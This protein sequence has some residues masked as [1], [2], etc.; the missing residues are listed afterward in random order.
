M[1]AKNPRISSVIDLGLWK[2]LRAKAK[3]EGI[4]VSLVVRDILMRARAEEEEQ[5]WAAAGE[6]RLESFS[7]DESLS[8]KD[9]WG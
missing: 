5:Y 7:P 3:H 2:W 9:V 6:E 8:H 4:S 1:P